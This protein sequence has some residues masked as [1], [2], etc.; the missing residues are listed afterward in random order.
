MSGAYWRP[1]HHRAVAAAL[2]LPAD[3]QGPPARAAAES[4]N[5]GVSDPRVAATENR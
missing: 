3:R 4:P 1:R 5:A 2:C